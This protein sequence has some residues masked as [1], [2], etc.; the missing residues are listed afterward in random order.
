V[1]LDGDEISLERFDGR[2]LD[3]AVVGFGSARSPE[4]LVLWADDLELGDLDPR[5]TG[6]ARLRAVIRGDLKQPRYQ[7]RAQAFELRWEDFELPA[8]TLTV[9]GDRD[10]ARITD[11][12]AVDGTVFA[13]GSAQ[14]RLV[15]G[16]IDGRFRAT[17]VRL[18]SYLP[19]QSFGAIDIP[20]LTVQGTL[21]QPRVAGNVTAENIVLEGVLVDR[22]A[23]RVELEN[24]VVAFGTQTLDALDGKAQ[25]TGRYRLA[26]GTGFARGSVTQL[27]LARLST[28]LGDAVKLTGRGD[29]RLSLDLRD[30]RPNRGRVVVE[31]GDI[32]V[33]GAETGRLIASAN[34]VDGRLTGDASLGFLDRYVQVSELLYNVESQKGRAR[35][36]AF[37]VQLPT[38][39]AMGLKYVPAD[40]F[41]LRQELRGL[42]GDVTGSLDA[43]IDGQ[44]V[45]GEIPVL[46]VQNLGARGRDLG[47]LSIAVAKAGEIYTVRDVR[48][49]GPLANANL[50]GT[51]AANGEV[52]FD[53]EV[54]SISLTEAGQFA[55]LA[56][57]P[58]GTVDVSFVAGGTRDRPTLQASVLADGLFR[59]PNTPDDT[60]L[61]VI[62]DELTLD[63]GTE[64]GGTAQ[65]TG[66]YFYR[67]FQG[68]VELSAPYELVRGLPE[69]GEIRGR[70]TLN[71]RTL[72]ELAPYIDAIDTE[73]SE[74]VVGGEVRIAG[75][76]NDLRLSGQ[77]TARAP[78]LTLRGLDDELRE[79]DM[80]LALTPEALSLDAATLAARGGRLAAEARVDL[81]RVTRLADLV[82]G[83]LRD[84][85][86]ELPVAGRITSE[87]LTVRQ[88]LPAG[89]FVRAQTDGA[90]TIAG[91][92][93]EPQLQGEIAFAGVDSVISGFDAPSGEAAPPPIN[94]RF[95]IALRTEG[96]AHLRSATLDVFTSGSGQIAGRLTE[97]EV[98][99]ELILD[100][101]SLRLPGG[102]VRLDPNGR[103]SFRYDQE[104]VADAQL[105]VDLTGRTAVTAAAEGQLVQR[106]DVELVLRGN[107]LREG[108]L[109]F[110]A[111]S[112]PPGLSSA[113]VL[114]LLGQTELI[115]GLATG[116]DNLQSSRDRIQNAILGFA[117]PSVL[118]PVTASVAR[119]F[120]LDYIT[121]E[122][123]SAD[124]SY[125]TVGKALSREWSAQARRGLV[126]PPPGLPWPYDLRLTYRPR[127]LLGR[128]SRLS[129]SLGRDEQREFKVTFEYGV[130]F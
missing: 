94:P 39:V 38:L 108:E 48:L 85:L 105:N 111:T 69:E 116:S 49:N 40:N 47:E 98:T 59:R 66:R 78:R 42:V 91:N 96:P 24:G 18:G 92:L 124:E 74:G 63:A 45:D 25:L 110:D 129:F 26:D 50:R 93:A 100:R 71:E 72:N 27:D 5:A 113:R 90:I 43:R 122:Y 106:Y 130:R 2:A 41:E 101:G 67:G 29:A 62:L 128:T 109:Q 12:R 126:P 102:Q 64:V 20:Q 104:P 121:L 84:R 83:P 8:A 125:I 88:S 115:A 81:S 80:T 112:D 103:M 118:D 35:V 86:G 34:L 55:G 58:S 60:G 9:E 11:F 127:R 21:Q 119:T 57:L 76:V 79:L 3:S 54:K 75:R 32:Q 117:L 56:D 15:S 61:R 13:Q 10:V 28:E 51:V 77:V 14:V 99:A 44:T 30:G 89:G 1:R 82:Q 46:T 17:G 23:G 68:L 114:A 65:A 73:R 33:N 97:P 87:G 123:I 4:G 31:T 16:A 7:L 37:N 19:G 6:N 120:G 52:A 53:G 36:D 70:A 95:D 22:L 107:L